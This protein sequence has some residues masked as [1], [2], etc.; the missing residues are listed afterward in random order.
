M[1][2]RARS[3]SPLVLAVSS[4]VAER[5]GA[6]IRAAVPPVELVSPASGAWPS[7]VQEAEA[8]YFSEDFWTSEAN[9]AFLPQLFAIP[10]LRWFHSFSAGVDHPAFRL[11]LERRVLLTN[12]AGTTSEPIAQYVIA[13]MLRIAK[14]LDAWS[15]GQRV[16]RWQPI[17]TDELTGKTAG[18]VG[19]GHIGGEVA[20]LAKAFR[21]RVI[22]CRRRQRRPRYVDE[23]L[24]PER[25]PALLSQSD[26]VVLAV[27]LSS[28]TDGLIA[29]AELRA[30]RPGAWLIN[31]SRGRVVEEEQLVRALKERWLAG[32]CL[33]VF[34]EEPLP[35]E[36]ELWSLPNVVV[37]PHNSGWSPLNLERGTELFLDNLT[38]Y[39]AGRPLRNR[40]RL[41]D[42]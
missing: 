4:L 30:M 22:G 2:K 21:M 24:P 28:E 35:A 34:L 13:M 6:R 39:A 16:R 15:E 1:P 12:S 5:H 26:F 20:R 42:L 25:L 19:V 18:I 41:S 33:D 29:E 9:R 17:E 8:A 3:R 23:L 7:A 37:T 14:R 10:A 40:I 11:L 32:A 27:P 36:S 38:R 31:V